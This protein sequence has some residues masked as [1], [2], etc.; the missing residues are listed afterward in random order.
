MLEKT[1][2]KIFP[3]KP[4]RKLII[5][6]D[7][8]TQV[9]KQACNKFITDY[10]S[11]VTL[12]RS[13]ENTPTDNAVGERFIRTFKQHRIYG[14]TIEEKIQGHLL[15]NLNFKSFRAITNQYIKSLNQKPNRKSNKKPS[16]K[17]NISS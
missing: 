12:S 9:L 3:I 6:T 11:I 10:K 17:H 7:R 4:R 15:N 16:H 1:L 5:Y 2:N 8:G 14:I 13:K